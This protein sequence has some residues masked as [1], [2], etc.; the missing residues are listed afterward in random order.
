MR[1]IWKGLCLA[2]DYKRLIDD[3]GEIKTE[4]IIL[5]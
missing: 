3:Y 5:L 4:Q 2:V 1:K